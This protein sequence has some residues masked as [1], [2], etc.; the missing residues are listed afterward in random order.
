[1]RTIV[2]SLALILLAVPALAA[3]PP[4]PAHY[5]PYAVL[6]GDWDVVNASGERFG[7][8]S[9][10]WGPGRSYLWHSIAMVQG[11]REVPH[12][13]GL[14]MWNGETKKLDLLFA[15]DLRGGTVQEQGTMSVE[16]DGTIVRSHVAID[17]TG[18]KS[19][20]RQTYRVEAPGRIA[21]AILRQSGSEWVATFPGSDRMRFV[22]R[23]AG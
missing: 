9:F 19:A 11:D 13:E 12:L 5:A 23:G 18:R 14:L 8:A 22:S 4:V 10:R 15:L 7:V 20:F 16:P 6:A 3:E 1:M 21:T 2:A 17:G